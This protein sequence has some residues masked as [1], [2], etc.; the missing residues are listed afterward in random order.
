[1]NHKALL[2]IDARI[3]KIRDDIAA[4]KVVDGMTMELDDLLEQ[5]QVILREAETVRRRSEVSPV[6]PNVSVRA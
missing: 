6:V 5:R 1:M 3:A 2:A 4:G